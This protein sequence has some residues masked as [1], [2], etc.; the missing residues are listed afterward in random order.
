MRL[1]RPL[2][3]RF[4]YGYPTR[5]NLATKHNSQAHSSKGTPSP[6]QQALT[7]CRHTVSGT[8]SLPSR[9][10]F[11]LSL[12]VLVRYRSPGSIQAWRV[13]PPDSHRIPRARCYLGNTF[14]RC[15]VFVYGALTLFG[16]PFQRPSTNDRS[17]SLPHQPAD[18]CERSHDPASTTPA[19]SHMETV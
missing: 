5:V 3:T 1:K 13:V 19:G 12:T 6:D 10:T 4:R 18:W 15:G 14:G 2:Q 8:I 9:G 17:F 7:A 16:D 11:H